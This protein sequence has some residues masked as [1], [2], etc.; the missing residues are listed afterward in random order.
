MVERKPGWKRKNKIL[1]RPEQAGKRQVFFSSFG[2]I[3]CLT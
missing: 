1:N 2:C 3:F